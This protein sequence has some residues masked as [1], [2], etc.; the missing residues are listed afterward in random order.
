MKIIPRTETP[1]L[2]VDTVGRG[3]W[4]LSEQKPEN[5]TL[6]VFYRGHHCPLCK[7]QL[8]ELERLLPEFEQRGIQVVA[9][10]SNTR[11]LAV[12]TVEEWELTNLTVG[13]GLP[14]D[15]ALR[16][17]LFVSNAIK[18]TEPAQFA[19]PGL[20]VI[21]PDRALYASMI[22]TMPFSRPSARQL[23]NSLDYI[24]TNGYPARGE[25]QIAE[26]AHP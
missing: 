15:E 9:V 2:R 20:F 17:G 12:K 22:Q 14:I 23:L 11:E 18:D 10:S 16:W 21:A 7:K 1:D 6:I 8:Q 3:E 24:V 13:Y 19:E 25:A 4:R 5:L 26:Q